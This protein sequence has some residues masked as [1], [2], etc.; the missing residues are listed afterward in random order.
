VNGDVDATLLDELGVGDAARLA[1][2]DTG[3]ENGALDAL[4]P[5]VAEPRPAQEVELERLRRD[6][7]IIQLNGLQL[8]PSLGE[9]EVG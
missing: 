5:A 4:A 2:Y 1:G 3:L 9:K 8:Y 7:E 6:D